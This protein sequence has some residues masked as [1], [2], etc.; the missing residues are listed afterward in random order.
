MN[1]EKIESTHTGIDGR[2]ANLGEKIALWSIA[3]IIFYLVFID[4]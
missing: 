1:T 4:K 3:A 2:P